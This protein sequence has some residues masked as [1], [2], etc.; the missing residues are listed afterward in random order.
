[1]VVAVD[2]MT[3][4]LVTVA[5]SIDVRSM[6]PLQPLQSVVDKEYQDVRLIRLENGVNE[7]KV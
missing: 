5:I 3:K 1:M 2:A 7:T 6:P 4:E